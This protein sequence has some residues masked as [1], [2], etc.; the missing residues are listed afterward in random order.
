LF[1]RR[2]PLR[3]MVQIAKGVVESGPHSPLG[4]RQARL[5]GG[6]RANIRAKREMSEIRSRV[7][8]IPK[9]RAIIN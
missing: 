1:C 5:S 9:K 8:Q 2:H 6:G 3:G 4:D 7:L